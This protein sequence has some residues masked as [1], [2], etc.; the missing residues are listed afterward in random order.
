[1]FLIPIFFTKMSLQPVLELQMAIRLSKYLKSPILNK[2]GMEPIL[3]MGEIQIQIP[4]FM[5]IGPGFGSKYVL[6]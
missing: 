5:H 4:R 6:T 3:D 2:A 1:M